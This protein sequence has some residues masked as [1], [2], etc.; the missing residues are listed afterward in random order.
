MKYLCALL[1]LRPVC[2]LAQMHCA[3]T[4]V[5][6]KYVVFFRTISDMR[7]PIKQ[8]CGSTFAKDGAIR[9]VIYDSFDRPYFGYQIRIT[10]LDGGKYRAEMGAIQGSRLKSFAK[11]PPAVTFSAN[12]YLDVPVLEE[13]KSRGRSFWLEYIYSWLVYLNLIQPD[14]PTAQTPG[15]VVDYLTIWRKGMPGIVLPEFRGW[16][17]ALP[18][19]TALTLDRP[20]VKG[21]FHQQEDKI[22]S[23]VGAIGVVVWLYRE[24]HGRYLFSASP[25]PG[26]TRSGIAEGAMLQ[27]GVH[28]GGST[29]RNCIIG[30]RSNVVPQRGPWW[31]WVKHEPGFRPPAGPW[32]EADLKNSMPAVGAEKSID[33]SRQRDGLR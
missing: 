14:P 10:L 31:I 20:L 12:E 16:A 27:F 17:Q 3:D 32:T 33:R 19:G 26:Y 29:S 22:R 4:L 9:R 30:L 6:D 13:V 24:G 1:L 15:R 23:E 21:A 2:C 18:T 11:F 25:R 28:D 8:P 7:G 5:M